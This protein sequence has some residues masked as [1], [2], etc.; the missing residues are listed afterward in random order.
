M[1]PI[2]KLF[3]ILALLAI[4]T[5]A[6]ATP[7]HAF[8]G[9]SGDEIVIK[10][11]E[12]IDDDLYV[13]ARVFTLDGI[14]NGD[15]IVF[16][17]TITINGT[18]NGDL[19]A[20]GQVVIVNG[21]V[22]DDA[23]IAG[24]AL[25]IG[26]NAS[27]GSDV[28]GAAASVETKDGS[29]IEGELVYA[30][31]QAL[32]AGD[33]S[34]DVLAGTAGLELSGSFGGNVQA[35]VDANENTR[36]SPPMN[37]YMANI[38][39]TIPNVQPGLKVD[40]STKIAGNLEYTSTVDLPI[41][42]GVVAGK[43]TR[44]APAVDQTARVIPPTPAQQVGKWVLNLLRGLVTLLL[45]G[46][47]LGWLF[48]FFMKAL[49][50]EIRSH[51]WASLG[52]GA[53][54]WAAFFFCLLVIILAM[55]FGGLI[56]GLL[57]LG[58][59]SGTIIWVGILVLIGLTILFVL[60]TSYLTKIVVGELMGK[61]IL[62]RTNPALAEHKFWPMVVGVVV[63]VLII[64]LFRFP[65]LPLGFFGWLINFAVILCGLG[66]LWLWGRERFAKRPV[67]SQQ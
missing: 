42:S 14:V 45:F 6:F 31:A 47:L 9:R 56:F 8:D 40:D 23:R 34:G 66:A 3:S 54:A 2:Q 60:V 58:G 27:I 48:P 53:I 38:P 32:L 25:L 16:A 17:Q 10:A 51:P 62:N 15:L 61:W 5:I 20:A 7:A 46:L 67:I 13:T 41:P 29:T 57:T 33:V 18:V 64:G 22:S 52:W 55:V 49:P 28:I 35:Y 30:G 26:E 21:T 4:V 44:T 36:S 65:L 37:M 50:E 11:G 1:K 19:I 63:L 43:V 24:A 59:V 12:E 39:I